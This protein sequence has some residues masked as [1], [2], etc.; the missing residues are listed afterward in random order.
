MSPICLFIILH[1]GNVSQGTILRSCSEMSDL[2]GGVMVCASISI[3]GHTNLHIIRIGTLNGPRYRNEILRAIV[4]PYAAAI[5]DIVMLMDD[6]CKPHRADLVED[7]LSKEGI[8]NG[9]WQHVYRT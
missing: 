9:I 3:E 2:A 7:F 6:N 1:L 8:T 5:G 4:V